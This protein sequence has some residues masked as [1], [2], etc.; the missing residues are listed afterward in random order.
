MTPMIFGSRDRRLFGVFEPA[1]A[2]GSRP[3][4]AVLCHAWGQEYLRSHRAMRRLGNMLSLSGWNVMRFDYFGTGDSGG[5]MR[6]ADLAGWESDIETAVEEVCDTSGTTDV[7]LVGLRLG[8]TLACRLAAR[9]EQVNSVVLWDPVING[10]VFLDELW[11]L[12]R[13]ISGARPVA[14]KPDLGG[15]HD[16]LGFPLTATMKG[17]LQAINLNSDMAPPRIKVLTLISESPRVDAGTN[18]SNAA[19]SRIDGP[20]PSEVIPSAPAWL[21]DRHTGAGAIP[22]KMLQR[23]VEW[24]N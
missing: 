20:F 14:R 9:S 2:S 23:I 7:A 18:G 10:D 12:E 19:P 6:D 13:Q 17:E 21:E 4:A 5:D 1:R 11:K 15:G 16:I 22:V 8:G 24:L 3:R